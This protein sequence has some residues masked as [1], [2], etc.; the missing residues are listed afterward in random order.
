MKKF[1]I[2]KNVA[3]VRKKSEIKI[4]VTLAQDFQEPEVLESFDTKEE[5]LEALKEYKSSYERMDGYHAPY[6]IVEEVYVEENIYDEDGEWIEGGDVWEFAEDEWT[7]RIKSERMKAGLTQQEFATMFEIPIDV[8][9]SW[10]AGR[11]SPASWVEKL[12]LEK[13]QSLKNDK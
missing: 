6:Y 4:G 2:R 3:E 9:K 5:A 1:E 12:I 10:D 11:R 8:V 7:P 13:M